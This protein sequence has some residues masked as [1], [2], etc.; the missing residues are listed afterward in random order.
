MQEKRKDRNEKGKE[1]NMKDSGV[2]LGG[3][4][5][6]GK[7]SRLLVLPLQSPSR[8]L[9][10]M[11]HDPWLLQFVDRAAANHCVDYVMIT[12]AIYKHDSLFLHKC[13]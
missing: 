2:Y 12:N 1:R 5:V 11:Q 8:F 9:M 6:C 4:V 7:G 10:N 13:F 3:W